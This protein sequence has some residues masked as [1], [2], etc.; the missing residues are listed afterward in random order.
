M[1][2]IVVG[3]IILCTMVIIWIYA[4]L[5]ATYYSNRFKKYEY[6]L[7]GMASNSLVGII[8][9]GIYMTYFPV[10]GRIELTN[11]VTLCM[12]ESCRYGALL[13]NFTIISTARFLCWYAEFLI[14][15]TFITFFFTYTRTMTT[16]RYL[17]HTLNVLLSAVT[18]G[19]TSSGEFPRE[20]SLGDLSFVVQSVLLLWAIISF[21]FIA[22]SKLYRS[23]C[24]TM[25]PFRCPA[26]SSVRRVMVR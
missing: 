9:F 20:Y 3:G 24:R 19:M 10:L 26:P 15:F 1:W 25:R 14:S 8:G 18:F 4:I 5:V 22:Q 16:L 2:N 7:I 13:N 21:W 17:V 6:E 23:P 11:L 12:E